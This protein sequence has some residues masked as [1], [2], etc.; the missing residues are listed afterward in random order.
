MLI[1]VIYGIYSQLTLTL[2][3]VLVHLLQKGFK[4]ELQLDVNFMNNSN[5]L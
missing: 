5:Y 3:N 1:L 4:Y 2:F